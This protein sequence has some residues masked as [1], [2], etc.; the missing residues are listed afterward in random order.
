MNGV[1][2]YETKSHRLEGSAAII[3]LNK[4]AEEPG[5]SMEYLPAH[6]KTEITKLRTFCLSERR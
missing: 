5:V 3:N 2:E 4:K 1:S 6:A